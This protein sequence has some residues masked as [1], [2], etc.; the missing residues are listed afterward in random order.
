MVQFL[1]IVTSLIS[2][3][4]YV[5][6]F[7]FMLVVDEQLIGHEA[8]MKSCSPFILHWY[9]AGIM[10]VLA[11]ICRRMNPDAEQ[12]LW[13]ITAVSALYPVLLQMV[14]SGILR[15]YVLRGPMPEWR[16]NL[17]FEQIYGS[18]AVVMVMTLMGQW[19]WGRRKVDKHELLK[20]GL[21]DRRS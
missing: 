8:G 13:M 2:V 15:D 16:R 10:G 21:E 7:Y 9:L 20:A 12:R 3:L 14:F 6:M 11:L 19:W 5:P 17:T 18:I 1:R 4:A